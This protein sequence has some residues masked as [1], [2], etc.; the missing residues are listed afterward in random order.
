MFTLPSMW[1]LIISTIIFV[2]AAWF[3][4]R[5]LDELGIP[6]GMTRGL[7]VFMAAYLNFVV[8]RRGCRLGASKN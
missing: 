2:I 6:K 1:N 3:I 7:G 5:Y 8:L 4:K